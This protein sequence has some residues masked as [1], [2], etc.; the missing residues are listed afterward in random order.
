MLNFL[1]GK[2]TYIIGAVS[3]LWGVA[4]M[5]IDLGPLPM[6]EDPMQMIMVGLTALGLRKGM[7]N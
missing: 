6:A 5:L 7:E 2:K 3:V 1:P 4:S